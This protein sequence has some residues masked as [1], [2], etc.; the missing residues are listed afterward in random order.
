MS[1]AP[2]EKVRKLQET[3]H[4]KAK[5]SP[6]Y[7]FYLL[8]DKVYRRDVLGFAFDR[9]RSNGGAPG[10]DGQTFADIEA[11]GVETW[12]DELADDLRK[13]TYQPQ[14][15]ASRLHPEIGWQTAAA[16]D[17]NDSRSRG[18]DGG[19]AGPGADLRGGPGAGAT[20]LSG[21]AQRPGRRQAG[22][23]AAQLGAYG[24][25]R[26]GLVGL[27]RQHLDALLKTQGVELPRPELSE[28]GEGLG[29]VREQIQLP[30]GV[31]R[32]LDRAVVDP[33]V[34]PAPFELQLRGELRHRQEAGD[35]PRVRLPA[36]AEQAMA[37][38][39]DLHGA[40]AGRSCAAASGDHDRS[41]I[42]RSLHRS[43]PAAPASGS[44]PRSPG[45]PRG[46]TRSRR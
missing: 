35:L 31:E 43:S 13:K 27:L 5:G 12:L 45:R 9:C 46:V 8:Y 21:R 4:A 38:P 40:A 3:L 26:R 33:V 28:P 7:R 22:P 39:D 34:D 36:V 1:L 41:D 23:R 2:P 10:I 17:R 11:Y 29:G 32:D 6:G 44:T 24:S 37:E 25:R 19:G 16:G 15:G 20:R 14:P 30:F 18:A 42:G